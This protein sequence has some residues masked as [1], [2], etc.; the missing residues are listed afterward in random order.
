MTQLDSSYKPHERPYGPQR[1]ERTPDQL[2]G[3]SNGSQAASSAHPGHDSTA[4]R[5]YLGRSTT[6]TGVC[7]HRCVLPSI[8]DALG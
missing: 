7:M 5:T 2:P 6:S 1:R 8:P 3:S 4:P